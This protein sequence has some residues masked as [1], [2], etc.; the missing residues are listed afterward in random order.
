M[1]K[2]IFALALALLLIGC[3]DYQTQYYYDSEF[4]NA[5]VSEIQNAIDE[6]VIATDSEDAVIHLVGPFRAATFIEESFTN[7]Y[8]VG[9]IF[10][11]HPDEVG[12]DMIK[13]YLGA[14]DDLD[15]FDYIGAMSHTDNILI[16]T[17]NR[18][19]WKDRKILMHEFGHLYG[20][21]HKAKGIM[22]SIEPKRESQVCIG[23]EL[24]D[25]FCELHD[26]GPMAESTCEE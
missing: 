12:Y 18:Q 24:L 20:L 9:R 16:V 13:K 10:K 1:K 5:E 3:G 17:G 7:S 2:F 19:A 22:S 21:G 26:C 6:W 11:V 15:E 23:Q 14:G 8:D 25:N 4:T